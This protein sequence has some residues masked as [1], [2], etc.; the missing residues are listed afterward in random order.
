MVLRTRKLTKKFSL[1]QK[2]F[3]ELPDVKVKGEIIN[4]KMLFYIKDSYNNKCNDWMQPI[5]VLMN[6]EYKFD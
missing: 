6:K 1:K 4:Q 3:F 5:Q 2:N